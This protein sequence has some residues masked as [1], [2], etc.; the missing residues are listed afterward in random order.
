MAHDPQFDNRAIWPAWVVKTDF[1]KERWSK[2]RVLVYARAGET[3]RGVDLMD[4]A[5]WLEN[6]KP[7][8]EPPDENT[9]IVFPSAENRYHVGGK[10]GCAARHMTVEAGVSAFLKHIHVYGNMWIKDGASWHAIQPR[11]PRNTFMRNDNPKVNMAANKIALNKPP[12]NSIE[13]IGVWN[14]GDEL[15]LFSGDFIVSPGSTFMPGD[16]ST[17]HI[18]P[19]ARLILTSGSAFYKRGNQYRLNDMEIVGQMLAGTPDRPLTKDCTLALSF[20]AKGRGKDRFQNTRPEDKGLI[21]YKEGKITV[22]SADPKKARLVFKRNRMET[23]AFLRKGGEPPDVAAM[24]HG[25]D[26]VLLGRTDFNGVEFQDVLR[27]GIEMPDPTAREQWKNVTFGQNNFAPEDELFT[28]YTGSLDVEMKD[29]GIA[30]NLAKAA[31]EN[32]KESKS[33]DSP[34]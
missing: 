16:R 17:Q 14:L 1:Y 24:P 21:L 5:N 4:P 33:G 28:R 19:D 23:D 2:A 6:G 13:W 8:T 11:G 12:G 31:K 10:K 15:D 20:K 18:Y 3:I 26:F 32:E 34:R 9:D 29:T 25:V 27:G 7:A 22:H 30:K